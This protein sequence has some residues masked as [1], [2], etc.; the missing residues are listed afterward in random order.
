MAI[1]KQCSCQNDFQDKRYGK[2]NRVMNETKDA[3]LRC[4]ACGEKK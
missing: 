2:G 1:I 4:T 3:K